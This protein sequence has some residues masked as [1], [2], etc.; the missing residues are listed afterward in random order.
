[1]KKLIVRKP[2]GIQTQDEM[3]VRLGSDAAR[4]IF[5]SREALSLSLERDAADAEWLDS[6]PIGPLR[7]IAAAREEAIRPVHNFE[8]NTFSTVLGAMADSPAVHRA[9][10]VQFCSLQSPLHPGG[11]QP[12]SEYLPRLFADRSFGAGFDSRAIVQLDILAVR[13][14]TL[15]F[16]RDHQMCVAEGRLNFDYDV[17]ERLTRV[18]FEVSPGTAPSRYSVVSCPRAASRMAL[19]SMA[20]YL[21]GAEEIVATID[22]SDI[23]GNTAGDTGQALQVQHVNSLGLFSV[24]IS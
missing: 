2:K 12:R 18:L 14:D 23:Y 1:M 20:V 16:E 4:R 15:G 7:M 10:N 6:K 9:L 24:R 3:S 19:G 17:R 21:V 13:E 5:E 22:A 8:E 11:W